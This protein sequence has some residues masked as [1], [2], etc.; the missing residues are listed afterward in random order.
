M[1]PLTE[2][3]VLAGQHVA[4][5]VTPRVE[6][7]VPLGLD[8]AA[9]R[10]TLARDDVPAADTEL[11]VTLTGDDDVAVCHQVVLLGVGPVG[12]QQFV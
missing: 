7:A 10:D 12:D 5:D 6:S 1:D 9:E 2:V 4:R 8:I 3:G 11:H